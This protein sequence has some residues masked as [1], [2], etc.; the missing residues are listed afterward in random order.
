MYAY[1]FVVSLVIRLFSSMVSWL[2]SKAVSELLSQLF[3]NAISEL[4]VGP[5]ASYFVNLL[6][7]L[8]LG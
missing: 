7:T 4:D 3:S 5:L 1:Y 6:S 2:V 8:L